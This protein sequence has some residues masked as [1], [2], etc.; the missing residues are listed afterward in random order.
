[1]KSFQSTPAPGPALNVELR[2][3]LDQR[4][5]MGKTDESEASCLSHILPA[6]RMVRPGM[7]MA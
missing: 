1:M 7:P 3:D 6:V 2:Q 5:T 4:L